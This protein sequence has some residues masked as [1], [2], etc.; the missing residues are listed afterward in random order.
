MKTPDTPVN[1]VPVSALVGANAADGAVASFSP[2]ATPRIDDA[3][4]DFLQAKFHRGVLQ[5][6]ELLTV[7]ADPRTPYM[8]VVRAVR[9]RSHGYVFRVFGVTTRR[10]MHLQST[11]EYRLFLVID[12][13]GKYQNI[14]EGFGVPLDLTEAIAEMQGIKHPFDRFAKKN[15]M[16]SCD[17]VC[18]RQNGLCEAIDY[19]PS[20]LAARKRV[21]EKFKIMEMAF[22]EVGICHVVKTELDVNRVI[23]GNVDLLYPFAT[24]IDAPPLSNYHIM[25]AGERLK[26]FLHDGSLSLYEAAVCV[27]PEFNCGTG[28]LVRTALWMIARHHW[29]VDLSRAVHPDLP[30]HFWN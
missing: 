1:D 18:D 29:S 12:Q 22:A 11:G 28:R 16:M 3:R 27:E 17:F 23:A 20:D 13:S 21:R 26:T 5:L 30:L 6:R 24:A 9:S 4:A 15:A 10:M 2:Q 8:P 7:S 25:A 14:R 19:K